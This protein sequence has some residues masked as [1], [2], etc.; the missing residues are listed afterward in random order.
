VT[1]RVEERDVQDV[2]VR[3]V[4]EGV[5]ADVV[6]GLQDRGHHRP[7]RREGQGRQ[8]VPDDLRGHLHRQPAPGVLDR[9]T[10][11]PAAG[12]QLGHQ[13]RDHPQVVA[14][15]L[16]RLG[17]ELDLEHAEAFR[18]VQQRQPLADAVAAVLLVLDR[19]AEDPPGDGA[20][21]VELLDRVRAALQRPERDL[22]VIDQQNEHLVGVQ[23]RRHLGECGR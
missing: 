17:L 21:D 4:V 16:V 11:E 22:L 3:R 5:P 10:V 13:G 2:A 14:P 12:D 19:G 7:V 20:V 1:H 23:K 8:L 6:A 9:V 18:A 15:P